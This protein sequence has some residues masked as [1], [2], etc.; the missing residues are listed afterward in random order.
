MVAVLILAIILI[1][2]ADK[3]GTIFSMFTPL[4]AIL[5]GLIGYL[6]GNNTK[7]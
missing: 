2:N 7:Q 4:V 6:T 5:S 3:Q 1:E